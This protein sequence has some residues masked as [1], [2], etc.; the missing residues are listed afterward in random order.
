MKRIVFIVTICAIGL[1]SCKNAATKVVQKG[2]KEVAEAVIKESSE[3]GVREM[4]E[5][6]A[7]Q[8][9]QEGLEKGVREITQ[10]GLE[11][12]AGRTLRELATSNQEFRVLYNELASR[13][14]KEFADGI[15]VKST[16]LG[17]ELVSK[18]F[19]ASAIKI[20]KN[21]VV[22]RAGSVKNAGPVNEFL[23]KLLPN[24]TYVIDD[25][26]VYKT[27]DLGRVVEC[28][29]KRNKAYTSIERNTQRNSDVQKLVINQLDGR[30]GMDDAGHLFSNT[31]GGPNELINQVPM[32]S[33]LNRTGKWRELERIEEQALKEGKEVL[34]SRKL[35]Y[36]GDSK[37]PVA[38][39][40]TTKID[41]V[42]TK[43]L[44]ENID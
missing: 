42:E 26:F 4:A 34:S 25:C 17:M 3:K 30:K 2:G 39:E 16:K 41:G 10:E 19:P 6:T 7:R 13:V 44:I 11:K 12:V 20:N 5:R 37:R 22:G 38:I 28:S 40:F 43:T 36:K 1:V 31:T 21:L 18:D 23:N 29:A 24:K 32:A 9:A 27:D 15:T 14:S 33:D 8:T 35:I